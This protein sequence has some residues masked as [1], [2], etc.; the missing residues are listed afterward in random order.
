[1]TFVINTILIKIDYNVVTSP[2][3]PGSM[4]NVTSNNITL[5]FPR[6]EFYNQLVFKLTDTSSPTLRRVEY[7]DEEGDVVNFLEFY[8]DHPSSFNSS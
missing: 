2:H 4:E 8:S 6:S 3:Y 5:E 1:M 7:L